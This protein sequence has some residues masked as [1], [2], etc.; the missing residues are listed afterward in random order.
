MTFVRISLLITGPRELFMMVKHDCFSG[1]MVHIIVQTTI[2]ALI[3]LAACPIC[4]I[5]FFM[6]HCF[7]S[8]VCHAFCAFIFGLIFCSKI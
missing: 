6:P 1:A 3:S 7:W 2:D 8:Q 4:Q 5:L